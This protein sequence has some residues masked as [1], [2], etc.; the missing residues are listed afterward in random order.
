MHSNTN[1]GLG[2]GKKVCSFSQSWLR[3]KAKEDKISIY[4]PERNKAQLL[5]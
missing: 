1:E 3:I 2:W 4:I 5:E